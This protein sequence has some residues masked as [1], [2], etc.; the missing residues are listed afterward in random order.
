MHDKPKN[1]LLNSITSIFTGDKEEKVSADENADEESVVDNIGRKI[2]LKK[3]KRQIL[4]TEIRLSFQPNRAEISGTT[5]QW[6]Q[7]FGKKAA[8]EATVALEIRLDK[9]SSPQLQQKRLNLLSNI[10]SSKGV[11]GHKLRV[12]YTAREPNSFVIR[13][14]RINDP[15]SKEA[16]QIK[17][18][19]PQGYYM[20]W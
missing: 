8:E 11:S 12:I 3:K 10:L 5:L 6:I 18:T 13:T 17:K 14:I 1:R 15:D 4:P 16:S 9:D 19:V 20:Q 7:A 2:G